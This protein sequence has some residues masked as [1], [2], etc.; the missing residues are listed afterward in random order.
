[1]QEQRPCSPFSSQRPRRFRDRRFRRRRRHHREGTVDGRL[2]GRR[3]RAGTAAHRGCTSITTSSAPSCGTS[4]PTIRQRSRR[5]FAR[6]PATRRSGNWPLIYGRLVG[7]SNAHF[8]GNVW[9]LR[10]SDFNEASA[11]RQRRGHRLH[12]LADHLRGSRA[13]LHEGRLG[14]RRVRRAGPFDPPRSKPL[15]DAAAAGEI[16]RR[17]DGSRARRSSGCIRSRRP[18]RSTPSST[19]AGRRAST[20]GSASSSC[21]SSAR[22]PRRW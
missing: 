2:H 3:A 8:T 11:H 20:A 14:N 17:A 1:M 10:P 16:V 19:T 13:V 5:P 22:S 4:M 6:R 18:W 7:G 15:S 9:R 21:A 12:R